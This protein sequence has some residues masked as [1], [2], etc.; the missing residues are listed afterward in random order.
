MSFLE[1]VTENT[2]TLYQLAT[3]AFVLVKGVES[4]HVNRDALERFIQRQDELY[5]ALDEMGKQRHNTAE[6]GANGFFTL[7]YNSDITVLLKARQ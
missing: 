3:N 6:F 2:T 4:M 1:Y 7:S 5:L